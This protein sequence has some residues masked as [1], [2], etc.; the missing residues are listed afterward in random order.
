M[1][2]N[3][4]FQVNDLIRQRALSLMDEYGD[5][6]EMPPEQRAREIER[7]KIKQMMFRNSRKLQKVG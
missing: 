4:Q 2:S 7:W 6:M 1:S 5:I 3:G